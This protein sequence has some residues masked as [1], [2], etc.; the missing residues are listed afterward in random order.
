MTIITTAPT[1]PPTITAMCE[2]LLRESDAVAEAED[3]DEATETGECE[4]EGVVVVFGVGTGG[5]GIAVGIIVVGL[6]VVG[7]IK[8]PGPISG[9]SEKRRCEESGNKKT[10][11]GYPTTSAH[12]CVH[13]PIIRHLASDVS[14]GQRKYIATNRNIEEGPIRYARPMRDHIRESM[15]SE[16]CECQCIR[17]ISETGS[18]RRRRQN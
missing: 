12:R 10:E 4:A 3:G 7:P 1:P 16:S 8:A 14:S 5:V 2:L 18:S 13:V 6:G 17:Y 11:R 9:L 15:G